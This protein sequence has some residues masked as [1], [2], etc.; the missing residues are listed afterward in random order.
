MADLIVRSF[1]TREEVSRIT[2]TNPFITIRGQE[3]YQVVMLG[4]L[5]NMNT[6]DFFIDDSEIDEA[7]K[8]I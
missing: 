7:R 3:K 2:V 8:V 4:M 6:E 1:K 5:R